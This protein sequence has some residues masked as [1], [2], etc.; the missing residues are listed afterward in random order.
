M[1]KSEK[2]EKSP[3]GKGEL[4]IKTELNTSYSK[5]WV[6]FVQGGSNGRA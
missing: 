4:R 1:N 3:L 2:E 5:G 6:F